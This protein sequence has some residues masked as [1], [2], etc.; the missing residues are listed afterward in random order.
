MNKMDINISLTKDVEYLIKLLQNKGFKAYAVGGCVRDSILGRTPDDWD[1]CTSALPQEVMSVFSHLQTGGTG[2]KHGTV[3]VYLN[4]REYE[5]TTLRIDGEYTD[6]RRPDS[7]TFTDD[8]YEDL[9]R[10]DFTVNAMAY[11][12]WEG[13]VDPFGGLSHI[14]EKK[15]ACVG[16]AKK[17]FEEDA[18][19]ILR[20]VRFASKLNFNIDCETDRQIRLQYCRLKDISIERFCGELCKIA[21]TDGFAHAL[22]NY[23][24]IFFLFIPEL[25]A[26]VGFNQNN[27]Y[28]VYDVYSH[29]LK[30]V[31]SCGTNDLILRLAALFH[32]IAKPVCFHDDEKGIRHFWG[33]QAKGAQMTEEIMNR[34][35][36]AKEITASVSLLVR[37][38]DVNLECNDKCIKRWLNRI[39]KEQLDR[40]FYLKKADVLG[41]N[42]E[43]LGS[44]PQEIEK[45]RCLM[46]DILRRKECIS[47][48]ELQVNGKMLIEAGCPRGRAVGDLLNR[49]LEE[50]MDGQTE[51]SRDKLLC[52]ARKILEENID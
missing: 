20:A 16:D 44:R 8:I 43:F 17:R 21:C 30:V 10:R 46:N 7:V 4:D 48:K 35:R 32:D 31:E 22:K 34:L 24:E 19:R 47:L 42:P 39:G 51:N 5:I 27:P 23:G 1:I 18:L 14:R 38:H 36:F 29:T 49:L 3:V 28:H 26:G 25:K 9:K 6:S 15:I 2:I 41:Q 37:Y 13:L 50:V 45:M 33:H 52:R 11:S 12:P 40:L